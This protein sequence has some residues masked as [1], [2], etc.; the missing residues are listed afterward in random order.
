MCQKK[1]GL[2]CDDGSERLAMSGLIE[3]N[4]VLFRACRR[5]RSGLFQFLA[6]TSERGE[7]GSLASKDSV[8]RPRELCQCTVQSRNKRR[9]RH[10]SSNMRTGSFED[11]GHWK[12]RIQ[13]HGSVCGA[14]MRTLACIKRAPVLVCR[15][16][17]GDHTKP[18]IEALVRNERQR[19]L[20][21]TS[22]D[23]GRHAF[24]KHV[25]FD[26]QNEGPRTCGSGPQNVMGFFAIAFETTTGGCVTT[27]RTK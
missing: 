22:C 16:V 7:S 1:A 19:A 10:G 5:G 6:R 9:R 14:C 18:E 2:K 15:I 4:V 8:S 3:G 17:L 27:P 11:W 12:H 20:E 21:D 23:P 13:L 24:G 26:M 25:K